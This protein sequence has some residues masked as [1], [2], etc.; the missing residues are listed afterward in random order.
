VVPGLRPAGG[1]AGDQ[2]RIVTPRKARDDGAS[3][4]VIG[5]PITRAEDPLAAAR[6]IEA[7]L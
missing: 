6:A 3:V 5:R 1:E 2:K 7:T 4:L